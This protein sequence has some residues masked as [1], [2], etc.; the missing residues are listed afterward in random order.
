[1]T[2]PASLAAVVDRALA[3]NPND[4]FATAAELGDALEEAMRPLGGPVSQLVV[5]DYIA[6]SLAAARKEREAA[7]ARHGSA[8]SARSSAMRSAIMSVGR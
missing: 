7:R 4:R 5:A 2:V 1:V 8:S 3:P 6:L